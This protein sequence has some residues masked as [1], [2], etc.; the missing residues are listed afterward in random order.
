MKTKEEHIVDTKISRPEVVGGT[1]Y[2][3]RPGLSDDT[4]AIYM[5]INDVDWCID[6]NELASDKCVEENNVVKRPF[7]VF[8]SSRNSSH[9]EWMQTIATLLSATLRQPGPFPA[10]II[11]ELTSMM[12]VDGGYYIPKKNGIVTRQKVN[13]VVHH[14]GLIF[15]QHCQE[16][17][18]IGGQSG[19]TETTPTNSS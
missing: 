7:E 9:F 14:I 19:K 11:D 10:Y 3:I 17:G 8:F 5:T 13:G 16:R 2:K 18:L 1:T 4:P 15:K 6:C 12:S